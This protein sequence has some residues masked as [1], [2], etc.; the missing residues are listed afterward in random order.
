M[1]TK[2][3]TVDPD[4]LDDKSP[5]LLENVSSEINWKEGKNLLI[6]EISKKQKAKSGKNKGQVRTITKTEPKPSFF[7]YFSEPKVRYL[8]LFYT[9]FYILHHNGSYRMRMVGMTKKMKKKKIQS[10]FPLRKTMI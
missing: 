9:P 2:A 10:S 3:Y 4:I 8:N 5:E 1:L 6:K 7:H